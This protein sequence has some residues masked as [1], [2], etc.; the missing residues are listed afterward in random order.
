MRTKLL[1]VDQVI[2]D[3]IS[4]RDYSDI[5]L[6]NVRKIISDFARKLETD[7]QLIHRIVLI[8]I[9]DYQA[10]L[11]DDL[12]IILQVSFKEEINSTRNHHSKIEIKEWVEKTYD[13]CNLKISIDCP[14]CNQKECDHNECITINVDDIW[15]QQHPEYMYMKM[16]HMYRWGG[17]NKGNIPTSCYNSEFKIIKYVQH[18]YS[19][20][21]HHI[22]GCT[23]LDKRLGAT[24][25]E[26]SINDNIIKVNRQ[27]GDLLIAYMG[28]NLCEN[29]Y[30]KVPDLPEVIEAIRWY[31]EELTSWKEFRKTKQQ[32]DLVAFKQA[33]I[34]RLKMQGVALEK[35]QTPTYTAWMSFLANRWKRTIKDQNYF[36]NN[37]K[38]HLD[39]HSGMLDRLTGK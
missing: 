8:N 39:R 12:G 31:Y 13:D 9:D 3:I 35:L 34:N 32:N 38:F 11:P 1:T 33:Q 24:D 30:N 15:R 27:K 20:S 19:N 18:Y 22:G 4:F 5:S 26:Y 21:N 28:K 17:M 2:E 25:I 37:N 16:D 7:E 14:K 36:G 10:A 23:N 6:P 29:G